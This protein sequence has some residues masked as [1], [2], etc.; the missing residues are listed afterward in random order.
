MRQLPVRFKHDYEFPHTSSVK[1]ARASFTM[2]LDLVRINV[3]WKRGRYRS[4]EL[5]RRVES[6]VYAID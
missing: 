1:L 4:D 6:T 2:L 3:N 5:S